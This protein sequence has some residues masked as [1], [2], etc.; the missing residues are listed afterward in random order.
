MSLLLRAF[1]VSLVLHFVILLGSRLFAQ[2]FLYEANN[3]IKVLS[4]SLV[5]GLPTS[6]NS[7]ATLPVTADAPKKPPG[8]SKRLAI[9][10][11]PDDTPVFPQFSR[12]TVAPALSETRQPM[13]QVR[14]TQI[15]S[16]SP[17]ERNGTAKTEGVGEYRLSLAREAQRFKRNS[18]LAGDTILTGVVVLT[19]RA[20][21]GLAVPSVSIEK[22]S[23][24]QALDEDALEM[25]TDAA[26]LALIPEALRG[27]PFAISLP[28]HYG[29]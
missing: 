21:D 24:H 2:P 20:S 6:P 7:P 29:N 3:G 15:A 17:I 23:G 22:N 9:K 25:M 10:K 12:S 1:A 16:R 19:V 11:T 5:A 27:K 14:G 8:A 18:I 4:A 26:R 13:A 28:V